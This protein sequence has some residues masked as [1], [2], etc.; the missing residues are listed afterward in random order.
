MDAQIVHD[1]LHVRGYLDEYAIESDGQMI[2]YAS[3]G[4]EIPGS[5]DVVKEFYVTTDYRSDAIRIFRRVIETVSARWI[6]TQT[7]DRLL[8]QMFFDTSCDWT[9]TTVLFEEGH[10]TDLRIPRGIVRS[11]SE[12]EQRS[13]FPHTNEPVGPWGLE[14]DGAIVATGG[15]FDHY[16]PPFADL[17]MEVHPEHRLKG[18]GSYLVQELR[19]HCGERGYRAS[20]RCRVSN[21]ASRAALQRGGMVPCGHIIR[22]R[23]T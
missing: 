6:E 12:K 21:H 2:G 20:A 4:G 19:R 11:L 5:R 15:F 1:S 13:T 10:R 9:V 7:N 14:V 8:M 18:F 16:N 17:Y 22:G 23:V 3:L